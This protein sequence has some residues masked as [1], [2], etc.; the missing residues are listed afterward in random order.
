VRLKYSLTRGI[1]NLLRQEPCK[2]AETDFRAKSGKET[3]AGAHRRSKWI[4]HYG[5]QADSGRG[6][7]SSGSTPACSPLAQVKAAVAR[8]RRLKRNQ[9]KGKLI[10]S[11]GYHGLIPPFHLLPALLK[12][13]IRSKW[14]RLTRTIHLFLMLRHRMT[15]LSDPQAHIT[16]PGS[17]QARPRLG[18]GSAQVCTG[19]LKCAHPIYVTAQPRLTLL[20]INNF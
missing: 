15:G 6:Q 10:L 8:V 20:E 13:K 5:G 9:R 16:N 2:G 4:P 17:A 14:E 12:R 1:Q 11:L 3:V 7:D 18:P 19:V